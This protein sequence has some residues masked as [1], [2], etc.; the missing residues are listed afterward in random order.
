MDR[1]IRDLAL[2]RQNIEETPIISP[3]STVTFVVSMVTAS[4]QDTILVVDFG[5]GQAHTYQINVNE[6]R[7]QGLGG[8]HINDYIYVIEDYGDGCNLQLEIPHV[9]VNQGL[10]IVN[11]H[12]SNNHSEATA[13]LDKSV[14]VLSELI[15]VQIYGPVVV[16]QG[17][18][19]R[20]TAVPQ[21]S[22]INVT[23]T[24]TVLD[25]RDHPIHQVV[26]T[27]SQLVYTFQ[28]LE[29]YTVEVQASNV[30]SFQEASVSVGVQQAVLG[31]TITLIRYENNPGHNMEGRYCDISP[32]GIASPCDTYFDICVDTVHG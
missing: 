26:T 20:F 9:Y 16:A 17:R 10:Y 8:P 3:E 28:N 12:A 2:H 5:D 30:I 25:G 11:I 32:L 13:R 23:Y 14:T 21:S 1:Q 7:V 6:P 18:V 19:T 15:G 31:L 22:P 24:W 29:V 27:E 4:R